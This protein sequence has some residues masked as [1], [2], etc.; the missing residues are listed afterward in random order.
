M[1]TLAGALRSPFTDYNKCFLEYPQ[2]NPRRVYMLLLSVDSNE[3]TFDN[4][5]FVR[6]YFPFLHA[7]K[8]SSFKTYA[9]SLDR[10]RVRSTSRFTNKRYREMARN[11]SNTYGFYHKNNLEAVDAG[12]K[13]G[14]SLIHANP[15]ALYPND[16]RPTNIS[17][18]AVPAYGDDQ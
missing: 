10:M 9:D 11:L 18:T 12:G 13:L 15:R 16:A 17:R 14:R 6:T 2:F 5:T 8:I 3:S 4:A 1:D 7:Q